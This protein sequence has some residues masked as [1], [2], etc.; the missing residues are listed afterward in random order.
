[1]RRLWVRLGCAGLL[2][3]LAGGVGAT[4][5]LDRETCPFEP[6]PGERVECFVLVVPENRAKPTARQ[7]RLRLAVLKATRPAVAEPLVYLAGGPGN[8]P[9][10]ASTAGGDALIEGDW[11]ERT[12]GIRR[13]RDVILLSQRGAGGS[14]PNLDCFDPKNNEPAKAR[15]WKVTSQQ[16]LAILERCRAGID[17]RGIDLGMYITEALADDVADLASAL[18]LKTINLFGVSYGTRWALEVMRRHPGLVRAAVLDGVY[19]PHVN[20]EQ[21]EPE[22]VGRAFDR[23]YADCAAD[24]ACIKRH[25]ALRTALEDTVIAAERE[26]LEV[27]LTLENEPSVAWLDSTKLMK[28]LLHMMRQGDVAWIPETIAAIGRGDLRLLQ[29]FAEDQEN[30]GYGGL[31]DL[32]EENDRQF[33]GLYNSIECRETWPAVDQAARRLSI[34][35]NGIYGLNAKAND[36]DYLCLAWRV[37]AAPTEERQPV[38]SAVPTLL[39]SGG[40]DWITPPAW[41]EQAAKHLSASRHVVVRTKGHAVVFQDEC[42]ARLLAAFIDNPAPKQPLSCR[43]DMPPDFASAYE[44]AR[45]LSQAGNDKKE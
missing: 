45:D 27:T 8:A 29:I 34:A 1:M 10:V 39:L 6:P 4:P 40:F 17:R 11:W 16:E 12:E 14:D 22:I 32:L 7:V 13:R 2:L 20:G 18:G 15:R 33:D 38:A 24:A 23:L 36:F 25:P 28:V 19:P 41:A 3:L 26:P 21:Q 35:R 44:A 42:A 37:A 43:T 30:N 31:L 5:R 9:L